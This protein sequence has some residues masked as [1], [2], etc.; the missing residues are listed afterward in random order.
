MKQTQ[1]PHNYEKDAARLF[2]QK[3]KNSTLLIRHKKKKQ[4]KP[5]QTSKQKKSPESAGRS[6]MTNVLEAA[7]TYLF[8]SSKYKLSD[9]LSPSTYTCLLSNQKGKKRT[10][11]LSLRPTITLLTYKPITSPRA[12]ARSSHYT[13]TQRTSYLD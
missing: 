10:Y 3:K 8:H 9:S 11:L 2:E 6:A 5:F 1:N 4:E 12:S 7:T 13:H